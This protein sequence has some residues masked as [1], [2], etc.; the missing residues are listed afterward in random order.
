MLLIVIPGVI[1]FHDIL[2]DDTGVNI[3]A[4]I[5]LIGIGLFLQRFISRAEIEI[6]LTKEFL[7]IKWLHQYIFH[8]NPDRKISF[9]EIKSYKYQEDQN[10]DLF[11]I[12]L[13]DD[14][15]IN[16]WHFTF[17][18]DDFDSFVQIF[19]EFI[20]YHNK[21]AETESSDKKLT[22][23]QPK[24]E[25]AKSIYENEASPVFVI[26][27]IG[28]VLVISLVMIFKDNGVSNPFLGLTAISGGVFYIIQYFKYRKRKK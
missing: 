20:E 17:T 27:A 5:C 2:P 13:I 23:K 15:E 7:T 16:F 4:S 24:I 10:F 18:K 3:I 11:Q 25:R 9:R 8:K 22:Y 19:P 26:L 12:T 14:T 21:I 6:S 28:V 1:L